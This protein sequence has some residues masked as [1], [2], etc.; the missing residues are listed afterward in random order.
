MT[1]RDG[2]VEHTPERV[3]SSAGR[4]YWGLSHEVL[5]RD[6][7]ARL[8][9]PEPFWIGPAEAMASLRILTQIYRQ[10]GIGPAPEGDGRHGT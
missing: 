1:W 3:A 5:I 7:Y 8:D 6:F 4:T 2:R 10:S 9:D